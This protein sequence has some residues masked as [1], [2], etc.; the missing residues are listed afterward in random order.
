MTIRERIVSIIKNKKSLRI[1]TLVIAFVSGAVLHPYLSVTVKNFVE[2][3]ST[4]KELNYEVPNIAHYQKFELTDVAKSQGIGFFDLKMDDP[5]LSDYYLAKIILRNRKGSINSS[6][7]FEVST[8]T[9]L[10]KIIDVKFKIIR[11]ANKSMAVVHSLPNLTWAL[12][13]ELTPVLSWDEGEPRRIAGYYVYRSFLR[14]RG[15]GRINHELLTKP[16]YEFGGVSV[17]NLSEAYYRVSAVG[18]GGLESELSEPSTFPDL[19]ALW[20]HFKAS[21]SIFPDQNKEESPKSNQFVSLSEAMTKSSPS[22]VYIVHKYRKDIVK[23]ENLSNDPRVFYYDDLESLKGKVRISLLDGIDEDG[24]INILVLYKL[25]GGERSDL[26]LKLQGMTGINIKR[27]G[28]TQPQV[29]QIDDKKNTQKDKKRSLTPTEVRTY[30]GKG[31]IFLVWKKPESSDYKGVR[32]FR[33]KKRNWED[34]NN[35]GKE[36]YQGPGFSQKIMCEMKQRQP[37]QKSNVARDYALFFRPPDTKE[38]AQRYKLAPSAPKGFRLVD[39]LGVE[40]ELNYGDNTASPNTVYTYTLIAFDKSNNYSYPILLNAS[41]D[42]TAEDTRCIIIDKP[43]EK[44]R[45]SSTEMPSDQV[46][47]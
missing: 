37:I 35:L 45:D 30:L 14:D 15:Y 12:P 47:W 19:I 1:F 32:I 10:A 36:L 17:E 31:I 26:N 46:P 40:G 3:R 22:T 28:K 5:L 34:L 21:V 7:R 11:P 2:N 39:V 23:K 25:L 27:V 20:P 33:S 41:L 8:G 38:E 18:I 24:E 9:T 4:L 13:K 6:L 42:S 16:T 29:I 44:G 43:V